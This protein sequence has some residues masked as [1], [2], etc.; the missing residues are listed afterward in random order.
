VG[1]IRTCRVG[2]DFRYEGRDMAF[3][4]RINPPFFRSYEKTGLTSVI[5][6]S[7]SEGEGYVDYCD[8]LQKRP[9]VEL[10][11][12]PWLPGEFYLEQ[13]VYYEPKSYK[14]PSGRSVLVY[15]LRKGETFRKIN[16]C[17]TMYGVEINCQED[18]DNLKSI[19]TEIEEINN[20]VKKRSAA[21]N[22]FADLDLVD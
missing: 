5:Y 22:R 18:I 17:Y 1:G 7:M 10:T 4:K 12:V 13:G 16:L 6:V 14:L 20:P 3:A 11:P 19:L 21:P 2:M 15:P 9:K 8:R